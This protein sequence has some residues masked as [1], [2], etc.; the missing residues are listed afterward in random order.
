MLCRKLIN[1][2]FVTCIF[3]LYGFLH[4]IS[5][6]LSFSTTMFLPALLSFIYYYY[7]YGF[8]EKHDT[9]DDA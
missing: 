7:M 6:I 9:E 8:G 3:I 2:M 1:K 5:F 4:F